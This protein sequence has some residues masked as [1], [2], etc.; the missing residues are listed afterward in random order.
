MKKLPLPA[1][2]SCCENAQKKVWGLK[3]GKRGL[4]RP[5]FENNFGVF[6][7]VASRQGVRPETG[8]NKKNRAL[9]QRS[10]GAVFSAV[11][12]RQLFVDYLATRRL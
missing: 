6:L 3:K 4:K 9:F 12:L 8:Q 10:E 2:F 5:N 11:V 1:I 7:A